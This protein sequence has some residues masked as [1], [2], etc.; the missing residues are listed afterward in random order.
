MTQKGEDEPMKAGHHK[1]SMSTMPVGSALAALGILLFLAGPVHAAD[2]DVPA[3]TAH[4]H[5]AAHPHNHAATVAS[6]S[7][8][9]EGRAIPTGIAGPTMQKK[10]QERLA[11]EYPAG[12]YANSGMG[13]MMSE[14]I[15]LHGS[16]PGMVS[17][18][19]HDPSVETVSL[20]GGA[21]PP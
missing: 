3:E 14:G 13:H 20:L 18:L 12:P 11:A 1:I 7:S 10:L 6:M 4:Q 9:S 2:S 5:S 16:M 8:Q 15:P 19:P 21:C 17:L